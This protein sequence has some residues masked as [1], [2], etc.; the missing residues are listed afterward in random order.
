MCMYTEEPLNLSVTTKTD[1]FSVVVFEVEPQDSCQTEVWLVIIIIILS[2]LRQAHCL[3]QSGFS[4]GYD[5]L[6]LFFQFLL[7]IYCRFLKAIRYLFTY[8]S[9]Y[10]RP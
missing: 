5:I 9:S 10:S 2:V 6:L 8:S 4:T 1:E 7:A 3:F